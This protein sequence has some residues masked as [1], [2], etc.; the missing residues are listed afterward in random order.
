[1]PRFVDTDSITKI[2]FRSTDDR[3]YAEEVLGDDPR[4]EVDTTE[5]G[6]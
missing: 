2:V 3:K 5:R 4:F 1:M 6:L